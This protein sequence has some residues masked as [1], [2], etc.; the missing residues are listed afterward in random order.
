MGFAAVG[1]SLDPI[2]TLGGY[3]VFLVKTDALGNEQWSQI[4]AALNTTTVAPCNKP[5]MGALSLGLLNLLA[6]EH[7]TCI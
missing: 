1:E 6:M 7:L 4:L 2:Q 5:A 3:D